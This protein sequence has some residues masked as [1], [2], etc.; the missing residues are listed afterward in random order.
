MSRRRPT[1]A[2]LGTFDRFPHGSRKLE[3]SIDAITRASIDRSLSHIEEAL[4]SR[5][6]DP[7]LPKDPPRRSDAKPKKA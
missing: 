3:A 1:S 2:P 6:G 4:K 5:Y 7:P